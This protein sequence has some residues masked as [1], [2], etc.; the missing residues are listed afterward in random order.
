MRVFGHGK[1][2]RPEGCVVSKN[3]EVFVS[4]TI[5]SYPF[6]VFSEIVVF[7]TQGKFLRSFGGG[8]LVDPAGI[9]LSRTEDVLICDTSTCRILAFRPDGTLLWTY[10]TDYTNARYIH[11]KAEEASVQQVSLR[12]QWICVG[13]DGKMY[14]AGDTS[15]ILVLAI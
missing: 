15:H 8:W 7:S 3:D 6:R 2:T 11:E 9:A 12:P 5:M 14:I 10:H 4:N 13:D 1:L